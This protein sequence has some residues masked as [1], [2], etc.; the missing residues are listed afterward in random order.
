LLIFRDPRGQLV[1]KDRKENKDQRD[2]KA[3]RD[4][5]DHRGHVAMGL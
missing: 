1:L 4:H 3:H 5:R 2:P